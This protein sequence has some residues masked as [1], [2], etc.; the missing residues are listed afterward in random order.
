VVG[1]LALAVV[2]SGC[3][4]SD[5][6]GGAGESKPPATSSPSAWGEFSPDPV[7]ESTVR[8][9]VG[10]DAEQERA[11]REVYDRMLAEEAKAQRPL[12]LLGGLAATSMRG[13][14]SAAHR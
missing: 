6:G 8:K 10:E 12:I 2:L 7:P 13:I 1:V 14:T 5:K 3:G 4:N 11:V 9:P